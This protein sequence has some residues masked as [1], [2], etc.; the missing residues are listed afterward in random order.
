MHFLHFQANLLSC[1]FQAWDAPTL[2]GESKIFYKLVEL[3]WW[4][5]AY[6]V[7]QISLLLVSGNT[8]S[9][10]YWGMPLGTLLYLVSCRSITFIH[11][12][13][14]PIGIGWS[15][16]S[17]NSNGIPKIFFPISNIV[18]VRSSRSQNPN[19]AVFL[20]LLKFS[21]LTVLWSGA[22]LIDFDIF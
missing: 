5:T 2:F 15:H 14:R 9:F 20:V 17:I 3:A 6:K 13:G 10:L 7:E 21:L 22:K 8:Q 12:F 16:C 4:I 19:N 18:D 11:F 1:W